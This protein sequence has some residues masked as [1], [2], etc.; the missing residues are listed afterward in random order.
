MET[1][2]QAEQEIFA[3]I[4][5]ITWQQA[6]TTQAIKRAKLRGRIRRLLEIEESYGTR[7]GVL[8]LVEMET[9]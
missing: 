3:A 1:E 2:Y 4:R 5:Q 6:Q 9:L 7:K 8:E